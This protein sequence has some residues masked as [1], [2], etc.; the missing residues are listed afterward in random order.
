LIGVKSSVPPHCEYEIAVR[1]IGHAG[2]RR[3]SDVPQAAAAETA[4]AMAMAT[5]IAEHSARRGCRFTR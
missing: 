5:P 4:I 3:G 1:A 2:G